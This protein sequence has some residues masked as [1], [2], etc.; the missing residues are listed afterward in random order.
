MFAIFLTLCCCPPFAIPA[1]INAARVDARRDLGDF[2]GAWA[3]SREAKKWAIIA[4]VAGLALILVSVLAQG[5]MIATMAGLAESQGAGF[6][7]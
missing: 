6:E 7:P 5:A 3:A 1:L 2:D 4:V